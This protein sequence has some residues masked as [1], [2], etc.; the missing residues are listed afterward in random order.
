MIQNR[1]D[2]MSRVRWAANSVFSGVTSAII[3]LPAGFA[4]PIGAPRK[5]TSLTAFFGPSTAMSNR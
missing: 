2:A 1:C 4:G 3:A 5:F